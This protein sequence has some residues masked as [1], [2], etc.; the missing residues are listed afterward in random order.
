MT[1][2]QDNPALFRHASAKC[3]KAGD[4]SLLTPSYGIPAGV[5]RHKQGTETRNNGDNDVLLAPDPDKDLIRSPIKTSGA[6]D[7]V[8]LNFTRL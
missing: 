6:A 7:Q 4:R 8:R 3:L 5:D 1:D 2:G